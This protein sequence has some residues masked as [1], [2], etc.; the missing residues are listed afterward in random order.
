MA[1]EGGAR[2]HDDTF[3]LVLVVLWWLPPQR[4]RR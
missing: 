1:G 4:L 3:E 2:V